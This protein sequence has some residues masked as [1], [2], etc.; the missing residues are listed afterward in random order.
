M[1]KNGDKDPLNDLFWRDE[2][3]Q[4]MYWLR[5]E[6]L[7]STVTAQSLVTFLP[8]EADEV[9]PYLEQLVAD[10]FVERIAVEPP[11]YRL[12]NLGVKEGGRRFADAF[13]GLNKQAHGACSNPNCACHT[14]GPAACE[15]GEPH[16][17]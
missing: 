9:V 5:G 11:Q 13:A 7:G 1:S 4:I 8:A 14:L 16:V 17:H 10:Q 12:T 2:I 6:A 3:L 15:M